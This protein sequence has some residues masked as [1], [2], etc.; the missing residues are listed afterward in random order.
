MTSDDAPPTSADKPDCL[1][2]VEDLY[3]YLD[4]EIDEEKRRLIRAHL[5]E[6]G[7]C[8]DAYGFHDEVKRIVSEGC[9]SELP[10]GLRDK[11]LAA[12]KDLSAPQG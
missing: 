4:G 10:V 7:P 1:G 11:V 9:R 2:A 6:C 12:I 3:G 5:D 8:L